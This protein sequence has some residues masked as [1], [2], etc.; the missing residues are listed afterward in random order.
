[1]STAQVPSERLV[2]SHRLG[3]DSAVTEFLDHPNFRT[4]CAFFLGWLTVAG[5]RYILDSVYIRDASFRLCR[6]FQSLVERTRQLQYDP[7]ASHRPAAIEKRVPWIY[8]D[9]SSSI[10]RRFDHS[11]LVFTLNL[12]LLSAALSDFAVLLTFKG[13][14]ACVAW[15]GM[16]SHIAVLVCSCV[17]GLELRRNKAQRGELIGLSFLAFIIL[18]LVFVVNALSVGR[19]IPVAPMATRICHGG[20]NL[21][22]SLTTS[23]LELFLNIYLAVRLVVLRLPPTGRT[24]D[25]W[26]TVWNAQIGK[27]SSVLVFVLINLVPNATEVNLVARN[28]LFSLSGLLLL[29]TFNH[30]PQNLC[31]SLH[32]PKAGIFEVTIPGPKSPPPSP[33]DDLHSVTVDLGLAQIQ[34]TVRTSF[35]SEHTFNSAMAQSVE[36]AIITTAARHISRSAFPSILVPQ[37]AP[38]YIESHATRRLGRLNHILP[39]QSEFAEMLEREMAEKAA[40]LVSGPVVRPADN[41]RLRVVVYD[42]ETNFKGEERP[43]PRTPISFVGS[44]IIYRGSARSQGDTG[45]TLPSIERSPSDEHIVSEYYIDRHSLSVVSHRSSDVGSSKSRRS[46]KRFSFASHRNRSVDE[47]S[48]VPEWGQSTPTSTRHSHQ[49]TR[50]TTFGRPVSIWSRKSSTKRT[51]EGAHQLIPPVPNLPP[52][53]LTMPG[54]SLSTP[55]PSFDYLSPISPLKMRQLPAPRLPLP[56]TP[57]GYIQQVAGSV[58]LPPSPPSATLRED[59]RNG[60]PGVKRPLRPLPITPMLASSVV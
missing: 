6:G 25:L 9:G 21:P 28:V 20:H 56:P 10:Q 17:L 22:V 11:A 26:R 45:Q 34:P 51:P 12:C 1:M 44:D 55:T 33:V 59:I 2:S 38:A 54:N 49:R 58:P 30:R 7:E 36:E 43:N 14:T 37:S 48:V 32:V 16:T 35:I 4:I 47:L 57:P 15:G 3:S 19:T 52:L 5:I 24:R 31:S 60:T 40:A 41:R 8:D 23:L 29:A 53:A 13:D 39:F 42:D 50:R 27:S 46:T 18:V